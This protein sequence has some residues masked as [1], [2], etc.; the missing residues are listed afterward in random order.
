MLAYGEDY[1]D[2]IASSLNSASE[3]AENL[4]GKN[5]TVK[6]DSIDKVT[7]ITGDEFTNKVSEYK[8]NLSYLNID[9]TSLDITEIA[10]VEF[11]AT[12]SGDK[13]SDTDSTTLTLAKIDG[14]YYV[15]N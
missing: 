12:I 10:E 11:T 7:P 9:I 15:L 1:K 14:K 4:Y 5:I 8:E 3:Q 2:Q 13:D 6:L